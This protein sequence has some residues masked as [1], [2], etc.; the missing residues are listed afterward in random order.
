[1]TN[2]V[3]K[4]AKHTTKSC[5]ALKLSKILKNYEFHDNFVR[6]CIDLFYTFFS[7]YSIFPPLTESLIEG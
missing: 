5:P 7:K 2:I 6:L 4:A 3:S 1:M